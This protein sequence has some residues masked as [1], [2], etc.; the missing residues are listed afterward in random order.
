MYVSNVAGQSVEI[1]N[2]TNPTNPM[3]VGSVNEGNLDSP[4]GLAIYYSQPVS[5]RR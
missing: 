1:Y 5:I 4:F 3:H 2:I